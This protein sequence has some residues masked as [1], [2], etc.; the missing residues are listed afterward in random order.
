MKHPLR[1]T[2]CGLAAAV[3]LGCGAYALGGGD[4]L[5]TLSYLN[6]TFLPA[7]QSKGEAAGSQK[8]QQT[9]D[10]AKQTLDRIYQEKTGQSGTT[11]QTGG[12]LAPKD[13]TESQELQLTTGSGFVL[14][15]GSAQVT[16]NGAVI[17]VTA[18]GE[19]VSGSAVKV[20]HRYLVG[21]DTVAQVTVRSCYAA[22]GVEGNCS[23][24][25]GKEGA[26]PFAD[27]CPTDWFCAPVTYVYEKGLFSGMEAHSFA[28]AEPMNRAMLMAVLY[29]MAGSPE[30][31]RKAA[32]VSFADVPSSA[33]YA[34]YV[35]WGA[36]RQIA[37]GTGDGTFTPEGQVT[38][39]QAAALLYR[40]AKDYLHK[41]LSAGADLS[42]YV[43]LAESSEWA[44]ESL[45]WAVGSG[46]IASTS[47][48]EKVLS[49]A[50]SANRAEVATMLRAFAE[51]V[52]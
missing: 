20:G 21:E 35:R 26:L 51:K 34:P 30:E 8:L 5:V 45:A 23:A 44:R 52:L 11:A 31:E 7:A 41:E 12:S 15:Q 46:V 48:E 16:H 17:D 10:S 32:D 4:S 6:G 1:Y 42:G 19:T 28:P 13:C 3:V 40:F 18:G 25:A 36:A 43:D 37:A 39:E 24:S 22:L 50:K 27:V 49:P 14:A 38:R 2:L 29:R 47:A 33:W 9:Y